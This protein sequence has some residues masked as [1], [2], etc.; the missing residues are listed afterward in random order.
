MKFAAFFLSAFLC[1]QLTLGQS[2]T[3]VG[4]LVEA[5]DSESGLDQIQCGS[6]IAGSLDGYSTAQAICEDLRPMCYPAGMK[7]EQTM[8]IFLKFMEERPE[9]LHER[10]PSMWLFSAI[11]NA[12]PCEE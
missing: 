6:F 2:I 5:C 9:V 12:F 8:K 4:D 3:T 1:S 7:I 11:L 10:A